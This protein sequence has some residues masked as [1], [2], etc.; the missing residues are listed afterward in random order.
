MNVLLTSVGRRSY[1]VEYFRQALHG[2]GK[3]I[4]SN[5]YAHAAG[6]YAA[7][8]AVVTPPSC[9]KNYVPQVID[10]C[11]Q[12]NIGLI[13]SFHDLDVYILSQH[14]NQLRETGAVPLLPDPDWGRITL[15][16]YECTCVLK[17]NGFDVPWT[18][19]NLDEAVNAIADRELL[20]PVVV[21]A[22]MGFGSQGMRTCK[23][24]DELKWAY[25]AA[26]QKVKDIGTASYVSCPENQGVLI[27]QKIAGNEYCL[28]IVNDLSGK[29][30]CSLMVEVHSMRAGESDLA[31]TVDSG[32]VGDLPI[33]FSK[34]TK[35][36]GIWGIDFMDDHGVLRVI[37]I[38]PRFT[39]DYPFHQIAGANI[40][41]AIV[42]WANGENVDPSWLKAEIGVRGFKDLVP[43]RSKL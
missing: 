8:K 21:K 19:I 16:K 9:D 18:S 22:R 15:D 28:D 14:I 35:H 39:G 4:C 5:M 29:Y 43:T 3:V 42:A 24:L 31:T 7:D 37:D 33:R 25:D 41:A 32:M 40:P 13:F 1:L 38:N 12:Y 26:M 34:M 27:Q 36:L 2:R 20:F 17:E 23:D 30:A 11:R 6:M 10:I